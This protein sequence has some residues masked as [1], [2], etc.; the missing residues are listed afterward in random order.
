MVRGGKAK[1]GG[2]FGGQGLLHLS[3]QDSHFE[4]NE[5]TEEGGAIYCEECVRLNMGYP[6]VLGSGVWAVRTRYSSYCGAVSM[7]GMGSTA[8]EAAPLALFDGPSVA[9]HG[10]LLLEWMA[11]LPAKPTSS[12]DIQCRH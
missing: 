3:F 11:A 9:T 2:G 5:A 6:G 8:M 7:L 4:A 10:A 1:R 12:A